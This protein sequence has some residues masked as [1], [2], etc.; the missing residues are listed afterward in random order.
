MILMMQSTFLD[1]FLFPLLLSSWFVS[2]F[3]KAKRGGRRRGGGG[4]EGGR[5]GGRARGGRGGFLAI[6]YAK[7]IP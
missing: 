7:V 3:V 4:R 2:F 5:W 6:L 1:N